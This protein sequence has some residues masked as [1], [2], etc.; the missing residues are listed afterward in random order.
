MTPCLDGKVG[1][2]ISE[3][4]AAAALP[5]TAVKER[6]RLTAKDA[7]IVFI[8]ILTISAHEQHEASV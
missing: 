4:K 6:R 5:V 3:M 8:F 1:R 2:N 7:L